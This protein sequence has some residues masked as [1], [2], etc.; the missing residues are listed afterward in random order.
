MRYILD[1][2]TTDPSGLI[3][4]KQKQKHQKHRSKHIASVTAHW[5]VRSEDQVRGPWVRP[6][7]SSSLY[8]L[9]PFPQ[10]NTEW[11]CM[12]RADGALPDAGKDPCLEQV[13]RTVNYTVNRTCWAGRDATLFH[14]ELSAFTGQ[15]PRDVAPSRR[16]ISDAVSEL[17]IRLRHSCSS[18]ILA[19]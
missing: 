3:E 18:A 1:G 16:R 14:G 10:W 4:Q 5:W 11:I 12:S 19:R 2:A 7:G 17:R 8:G 6:C 13:N 9:T 15:Y